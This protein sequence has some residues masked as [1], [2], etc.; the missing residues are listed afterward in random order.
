MLLT[1]IKSIHWVCP[2][3]QT[4]QKVCSL[5]APSQVTPNFNACIAEVWCGFPTQIR[6]F[7][8]CPTNPNI[9]DNQ[10]YITVARS[11]FTSLN[12]SP[13]G[14]D[15]HHFADDI[16]WCIF[17]NENVRSW[18][19]IWLKFVLNG[20]IE[21]KPALVQVMACGRTGDKLLPEPMVTQIIDIY[22]SLGG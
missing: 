9:G 1:N 13:P 17:L 19:E 16:F 21:D 3:K 6:Q 4:D 20:S 8:S 5:G 12:S 2:E 11:K 10:I 22:A 14:Q 7:L 18:I 15:G